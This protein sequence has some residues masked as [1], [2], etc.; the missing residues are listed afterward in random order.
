MITKNLKICTWN[1]CLG[2]KYK[3][4]HIKN[5]LEEHAI[6]ILCIQEVEIKHDD[7]PSWLDGYTRLLSG[8]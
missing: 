1:V 8:S 3:K 5:L 6:D 7:D 4:H 2:A